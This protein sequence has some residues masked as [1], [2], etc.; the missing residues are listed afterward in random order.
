MLLK[1][2]QLP[3]ALECRLTVSTDGSAS[4]ANLQT[5]ACHGLRFRVLGFRVNVI[6]PDPGKMQPA[7]KGSG[8]RQ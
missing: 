3:R 1:A 2:A 8:R 4:T 6:K 7:R 5:R